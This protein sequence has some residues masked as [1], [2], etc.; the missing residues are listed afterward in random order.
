[1]EEDILMYEAFA[2]QD[3]TTPEDNT[4]LKI[5]FK[6]VAHEI[7]LKEQKTAAKTKLKK[8]EDIITL[9]AEPERVGRWMRPFTE[10]SGYSGVSI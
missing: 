4:S 3:S 2:Y 5:R 1:M 8:T 9:D 6:K 10:V 7:I